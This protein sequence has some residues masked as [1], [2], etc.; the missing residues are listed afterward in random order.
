MGLIEAVREYEKRKENLAHGSQFSN[1][2][3]FLLMGVTA[4]IV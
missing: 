4:L 3:Y 1:S 2:F